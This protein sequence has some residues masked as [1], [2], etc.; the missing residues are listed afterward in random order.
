[1]FGK[2]FT[3][4]GGTITFTGDASNP[5]LHV[6]AQW[7]AP[8]QTRVFAD[9]IGTPQKLDVNLR[10]EPSRSQDEIVSLLV[11]GSP[12]GIAG[13]GTAAAVA[14]GPV[15][16]AFNKALSGISAIDVRA[17]LDTSQVQN[18]R[19]ELELRLSNEVMLSILQNLGTPPPDQPDRT[20]FT[21][22]W[23]FAPR[24]SLA[25]T[26]GDAGTSL[27]DFVWRHRY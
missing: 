13:V 2:R 11:F 26:V 8:D 15:V 16:Q 5:Q 18:P 27:I 4:S 12:E 20:L 25:T 17:R 7:D 23:R 1:V 22:D 24:W 6:T 10:S 21:L 19:P 9:L 3:I 14:G